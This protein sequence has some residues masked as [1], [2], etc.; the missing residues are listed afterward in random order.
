MEGD[1]YH[2]DPQAA[3]DLCDENTIGVVG[4]LGST[5]DG[6]YEPIAELCAALDALQSAPA[7]TSRSMSTGRRAR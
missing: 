4:V 2:L 7:W 5:F 1:R 3:A 6:S